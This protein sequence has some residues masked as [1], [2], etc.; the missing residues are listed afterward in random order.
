[1]W[2]FLFFSLYYIWQLIEFN[3]QSSVYT[4]IVIPLCSGQL[5]H[6]LDIWFSR[7]R[8]ATF[9]DVASSNFLEIDRSFYLCHH[10]WNVDQF[11]RHTRRYL[12]YESHPQLWCPS[13]N[14][15]W[16]EEHI[17][18]WK[19]MPVQL[20]FCLSCNILNTNTYKAAMFT[21]DFVVASSVVSYC[22]GRLAITAHWSFLIV[23]MSS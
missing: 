11:L 12:L 22:E 23:T 3:I 2:K 20:P 1:M 15:W 7:M 19:W 17:G 5:I 13:G 10:L 16:N 18:S 4:F 21:P 14:W 8:V 9:W 6:K